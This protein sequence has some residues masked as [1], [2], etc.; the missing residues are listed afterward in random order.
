MTY[1]LLYFFISKYTFFIM[2]CAARDACWSARLIV[3][4]VDSNHECYVS[5]MINKSGS[6]F[7]ICRKLKCL[8]DHLQLLKLCLF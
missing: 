8:S 5:F 1:L 6:S 3:Q 4:L 7:S 2:N